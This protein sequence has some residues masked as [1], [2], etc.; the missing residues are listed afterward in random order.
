MSRI[1][2]MIRELCPEGVS[3]VKVENICTSVMGEFVRKDKQN[4]NGKYPV[5]N[6][7]STN[8]GWYDDYNTEANKIIISAR[9]AAG[10]VNKVDIPFWA[11]NS[12]H[13]V[14]I[15]D[16][17]I[18]NYHYLYYALKQAET[19]LMD[20]QQKGGG[21]PAVS[22]KQ[23]E[24]LEIPLPPLS[25]QQKIVSVLDSF[26]TLIDKMKQEVEKR[27]KQ[28][29]YYREKLL[30]LEDG[31]RTLSY[32]VF[33]PKERIDASELDKENY[34]SVENL[35]KDKA[36]KAVSESVPTEGNWIKYEIG[37]VLIG[38]IRPYLKKIWLADRSGGTNGDVVV[39]RSNKSNEIDCKYLYYVLSSDRFFA[40]YNNTAKGGKMPRGD[41]NKLMDYMVYFPSLEKQSSIVSILDK[42]ESYISKLEKMITLRQKQYEY[43]REQLLT[44]E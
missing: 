12:C 37:D 25:I 27:K 31:E 34:V 36:G 28:M 43:Y 33:Q 21:V 22:K 3:Y 14:T 1:D 26:T 38:N 5:Y 32:Y 35:L 6:G 41:K 8:T 15:K 16:L 44:F 30:T 7:G 23:V 11:G 4:P 18:T 9:G 20:N 19:F 40:F 29:E 17:S 2:E 24:N 42:F 10:F 39:L 13:V